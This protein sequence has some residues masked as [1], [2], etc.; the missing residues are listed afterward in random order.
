MKNLSLI[1]NIVLLVAVGVLYYLQFSGGK[2]S[3]KSASA[4]SVPSDVK[5]AYVN[6]DSILKHYDYFDMRTK[7]LEA[8]S[9]RLDQEFRNRAQGLQ[10]E[11]ANYQR[12]V[13][14]LTLSQVKAVE[15]DLGKKQQNLQLYQ[16]S[17]NQELAQDEAKLNRDLYQKI[18]AFLKDYSKENGLQVVLKYD[19]SSDVLYGGDALDITSDVLKGLNEKYK[20]E[21]SGTKSASDS[22]KAK[23]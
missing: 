19:P 11:Y 13:N 16:Q 7:A 20:E 23:K 5:I 9:Q 10:D 15:E 2:S 6:S 4:S 8:K 18:T 3:M 14:N 12:T 22:T 1:L 17:L 21:T